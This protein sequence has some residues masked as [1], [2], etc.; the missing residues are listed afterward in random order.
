MKIMLRLLCN[1]KSL[2]TIMIFGY[3]C[4]WQKV[5]RF[6]LMRVSRGGEGSVFVSFLRSFGKTVRGRSDLIGL[7]LWGNFP[8]RSYPGGNCPCEA[9]SGREL[10]GENCPLGNSPVTNKQPSSGLDKQIFLR[11]TLERFCI[12]F[13]L[14]SIYA[15]E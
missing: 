1:I 7:L 3:M 9:I 13:S 4:M 6:L 10:S 15:C 5:C 14:I 2:Q 12:T 8:G 11:N